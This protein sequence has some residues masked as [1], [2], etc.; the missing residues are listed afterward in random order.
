MG[1]SDVGDIDWTA[2][3]VAL[4]GSGG[5]L[6]AIVTARIHGKKS[7]GDRTDEEVAA[8]TVAG[9]ATGM[10]GYDVE[11]FKMARQAMRIA[12]ETRK[13]N[14]ATEARLC[15]VEKE[16]GL[17]RKSYER[18]WVWAQKVVDQWHTLRVEDEPPPLPHEIHRP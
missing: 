18:L 2:V 11:T 4:V 9:P 15:E 7:P 3:I 16:L 10:V 14:E 6:A 13:T 12:E 1:G 17:L 8:A 5:L